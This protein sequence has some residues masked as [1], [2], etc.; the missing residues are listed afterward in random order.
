MYSPVINEKLIPVLYHTA[1]NRNIPMTML[2]DELLASSLKNQDLPTK[3]REALQS[4]NP[5]NNNQR[6]E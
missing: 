1:R 3:A 5:E 2:V 6:K 4:I